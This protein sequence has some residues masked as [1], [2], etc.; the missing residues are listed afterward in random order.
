MDYAGLVGVLQE[1][2]KLVINSQYA[3]DMRSLL[4]SLNSSCIDSIKQEFHLN[5]NKLDLE[6]FLWL[7]R[8]AVGIDKHNYI[9]YYELTRLFED[10]DIDNSRTIEWQ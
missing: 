8:R 1:K 7:L 6:K 5:E 3:H 10:I 2:E 4:I 9:V